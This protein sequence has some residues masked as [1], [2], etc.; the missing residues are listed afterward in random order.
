MTGRSS[1]VNSSIEENSR[2]SPQGRRDK[3][4]TRS[5]KKQSYV[6]SYNCRRPEYRLSQPICGWCSRNKRECVYYERNR[7]GPRSKQASEQEKKIERLEA[8]LLVLGRRVEDH[9]N[10]D[11]RIDHAGVSP[12]AGSQ[13]T[14]TMLDST[15][16]HIDS[17]ENVQVQWPLD[18][19]SILTMEWPENSARA[20]HLTSS[21]S[22]PRLCWTSEMPDP[23]LPPYEILYSLVDL[24]FKHVNTW[25]PILD[26]NTTF[27]TFFQHIPPNEPDRILLHAIVVTCLRFSNEPHLTPEIRKKYSNVSKQKV[28]LYGLENSNV[29]A[30]QALVVVSL[31]VLGTSNGPEGWNLLAIIARN[32]TQLGLGAEKNFGLAPS[33][34]PSS[35]TIRAFT[36]PRPKSWIED[37]ERRRLFWMVYVLDRYATICTVF[38]FVLGEKQANR[39]LPCRYDLF[40]ENQPVETRWFRDTDRTPTGINKPENLGSFSYHCEVLRILSRV[41]KFLNTPIDIESPAEVERWQ[42]TYWTL[43]SQ[44]DSW[45]FNLP[46]EYDKI[47][48][49]CHSDPNSKIANWIILHAAYVT[50]VIRLHSAAAYPSVHSHIFKPSF[51][52]MQR[53]LAAVASLK[54]IAMDVINTGMLNLLGP[55]FALSLWISARLLIVHASIAE[56]GLDPNVEIFVSIL[57]QM[58]QY[59]PVAQKYSDVLTRLLSQ[60]RPAD[61]TVSKAVSSAMRAFAE[62][63]SRAYELNL[64]MVQQRR[65]VLEP[66]SIITLAPNEIEYLDVFDFF[67]YPR[68]NLG[69]SRNL[70]EPM[71]I[72]ENIQPINRSLFTHYAIPDPENDWSVRKMAHG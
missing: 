30:L 71:V 37:E 10:G 20:V 58:G 24:Y 60:H 45:S 41:H 14:P 18:S 50:T 61:Q 38:A 43:D 8:M 64:L 47:S 33:T 65:S 3:R 34:D 49:L 62:M 2:T 15:L 48:Q 66:I 70:Q 40:S 69:N 6:P 35:D 63:R 19:R 13:R 29:R 21:T 1:S 11:Q 72:G 4:E 44:L 12:R 16:P 54:E 59:W 31:D 68:L 22:S 39:C 26:R 9:I 23:D 46:D 55:P 67:N 17:I 5:A 53:C 28:Q 52:A 7:P 36:L 25:C 42:T 27:D 57:D 51:V 32:I 56:H